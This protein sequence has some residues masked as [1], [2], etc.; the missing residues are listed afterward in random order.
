MADLRKLHYKGLIRFSPLTNVVLTWHSNAP[1]LGN[2]QLLANFNF[3]YFPEK[4]VFIQLRKLLYGL[5]KM[6]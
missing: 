1:I 2:V 6:A 3:Q 4:Q 5:I